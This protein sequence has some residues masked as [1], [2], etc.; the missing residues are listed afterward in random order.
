MEASDR[1]AAP[2]RAPPRGA[3]PRAAA[4]SAC[5]GATGLGERRGWGAALGVPRPGAVQGGGPWGSRTPSKASQSWG[6]G[7]GEGRAEGG[8]APW[9]PLWLSTEAPRNRTGLVQL[10]ASQLPRTPCVHPNSRSHSPPHRHTPPLTKRTRSHSPRL[11]GTAQSGCTATNVKRTPSARG[12]P[13]EPSPPV[14]RCTSPPRQEQTTPPTQTHTLSPNAHTHTPKSDQPHRFT[15]TPRSHMDDPIQACPPHSP[16]TPPLR[17]V[18]R[19]RHPAQL[20]LTGKPRDTPVRP[21]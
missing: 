13:P 14:P 20:K 17:Y 6:A 12:R 19:C 1:G 10:H 11:T 4:S 18:P 9:R 8:I 16:W 2:S 15:D 3:G 5:A 7:G 21:H